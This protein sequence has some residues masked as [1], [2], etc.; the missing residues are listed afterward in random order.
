MRR[1]LLAA[2][3]V[4]ATTMA[5]FGAPADAA[6]VYAGTMVGPPFRFSKATCPTG[7]GTSDF[8]L[9]TGDSVR[10]ENCTQ[11]AHTVTGDSFGSDASI[12]PG[13]T[14]TYTFLTPGQYAYQCNF[15]PTTMTGTVTVEGAPVPTTAEPPPATTTTAQPTT[16]TTATTLPPT[17]T[18][19]DDLGGVFDPETDPTAPTTTV[20]STDTTRALGAGGGDT[21]GPLIVLLVV[22]LAGVV[23]TAYFVIRRL[24][25]APGDEAN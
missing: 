3:V 13:E 10:W 4:A 20:F 8:T 23:S 19:A 5:G 1:A 24:R 14:V 6:T 18:T 2:L 7:S 22:A 11:V 9:Q 16:T 15:H 25:A 21:S 12:G 17:T